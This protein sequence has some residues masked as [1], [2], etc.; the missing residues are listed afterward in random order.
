M[1]G[2]IDSFKS[3]FRLILKNRSNFLKIEKKYVAMHGR[4]RAH[5]NFP[6]SSYCQSSLSVHPINPH[7]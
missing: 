1:E 5:M 3:L 6:S 7:I 4:L 2:K